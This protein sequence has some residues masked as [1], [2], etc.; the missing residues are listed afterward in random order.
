[1]LL[2][3]KSKPINCSKF[4]KELAPSKIQ[5]SFLIYKN[6]NCGIFLLQNLL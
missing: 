4:F 6:G 2:K 1:M 5:S 3:Y